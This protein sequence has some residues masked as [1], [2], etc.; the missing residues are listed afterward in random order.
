MG[1]HKRRF[2]SAL[3]TLATASLGL[4]VLTATGN[5]QPCSTGL[6]VRNINDSA[7]SASLKNQIFAP[8]P[9][10]STTS[11][12]YPSGKVVVIRA[13]LQD[14]PI[15]PAATT[16]YI[17][18]TFYS[19]AQGVK[20]IRGYYAENSWAQ[21]NIVNGA[22]PEWITIPKNISDYTNGIEQNAV[23]LQD[24]LK[25]AAVNWTALDTNGD[26][27]ISP[28][29]AQIVILVP[30]AMPGTGY[31]STRSVTAG[32]VVMRGG[33]FDFSKRNIV[34]FSLKSIN[35]P[36][37]DVD[38][39][40]QYAGICHELGHAFFNL[41][42]YYGSNTGTGEYD[43]MGSGNSSTWVHLTIHDK[44][45]IGW[46]RPKIV[47]GHLGQ[48]VSFLAEELQPVALIVVPITQFL[49]SPLEYW[50]VENRDKIASG[51]GY[52]SDLPGH[53]L[54]IWYSS[55]GTYV[56]GLGYDDLRLVDFSKP[57]EDPDLYNHPGSNA[58]FTL[59]PAEPQ[60]ILLDRNGHWNLLNFTNISD[61]N[62]NFSGLYMFGEF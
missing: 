21:F 35:D 36:Q 29:E 13:A 23:F 43:M 12:N 11:P 61:A 44:M 19:T 57:D 25:R 16:Q 7:V 30:N 24:V 50:I 22:T 41:T 31:A 9:I 59:N 15:N 47:Q 60:R 17:N 2:V 53:G 14:A 48:C 34:I 45:K 46:I 32:K 49:N 5:A 10:I 26:H 3:S 40:R 38:P 27:V 8:G 39:I 4:I 33:T 56:N 37:Y 1:A 6:D 58:L 20:S 42:D 51:G 28:S 54:A 52:D 18:D 55:A 62:A